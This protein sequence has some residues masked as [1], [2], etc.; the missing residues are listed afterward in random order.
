MLNKVSHHAVIRYLDRV[1]G[2][3]VDEWLV[4]LDHLGENMKA[5]HC[6]ERAGLPV[7]AVK[8]VI[9]CPA[10][11]KAVQSRMTGSVKHDGFVYVLSGGGILTI[12]TY[13]LY[14]RTMGSRYGAPRE[15]RSKKRRKEK[16]RLLA[17]VEA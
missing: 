7:D 5:K 4:G 11:L 2:L 16:R 10:V 6:C 9:L 13:R 17:E 3:P 12:L 15:D 8:S 1:L 14:L